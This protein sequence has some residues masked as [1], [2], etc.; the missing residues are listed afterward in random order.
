MAEQ[1]LEMRINASAKQAVN[2]LKQLNASLVQVRQ[3][4]DATLGNKEQ[5]KQ[6][7]KGI[8]ETSKTVQTESK[9][10]ATALAKISVIIYTLRRAFRF[11]GK[12]IKEAM[13]YREVTHLF[14]TVFS[15]VGYQ[16][17]DAFTESMFENLEDFQ[18]SF[19]YLGFDDKTVMNFQAVFAQMSNAMGVASE[20]AVN[21]SSSFTALG[22]DMT[23]LFNLAS[24]DEAMQKLQAGLAGQIRPLRRIGVDISKTTLM[25]EAYNR[26]INKS[27]EVMSAQEK[28]QLRY[29]AI[30]K[31]LQVAMGDLPKTIET[32]ANQ[33]RIFKEQVTQLARA[34]GTVFLPIVGVLLQYLNGIMMALT[35][36]LE[37]FAKLVGYEKPERE[38]VDRDQIIGMGDDFELGIGEEFEEAEESSKQI[39]RNLMG[40]DEINILDTSGG[41]EAY[42][43]FGFGDDIADMTENYLSFREKLIGDMD[44][45]PRNVSEKLEEGFENFGKTVQPTIDAFKNLYNATEPFTGGVVDTLKIFVNDVLFPMG[46][47]VLNEALPPFI[48]AISDAVRIFGTTV[49]PPAKDALNWY[50]ND[51]LKPIGEFVGNE[52]VEFLDELAEKTGLMSDETEKFREENSILYDS[53]YEIFKGVLLVITALTTFK[54]ITIIVTKVIALGASI[55]GIFAKGF[56][57]VVTVGKLVI[58]VVSALSGGLVLLAGAFGVTL[59][60]ILATVLAIGTLI[61]IVYQLYKNWDEILSWMKENVFS[62]YELISNVVYHIKKIFAGLVNF[63]GGVLTGDWERAFKGLKTIAINIAKGIGSAFLDAINTIIDSINWLAKMSNKIFGTEFG[64]IGN[65]DNPFSQIKE[66]VEWTRVEVDKMI[67][68]LKYKKDDKKLEFFGWETLPSGLEMPFGSTDEMFGGTRQTS[69]NI[70][71]NLATQIGLGTEASFPDRRS[72]SD[73]IEEQEVELVID[74]RQIGKAVIPYIRE[75][76][77]RLGVDLNLS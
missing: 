48:N 2:S 55:V 19:K 7:D 43:S 47:F 24:S 60:P 70:S 57:L 4:L 67:D 13:D 23:S 66:D 62:L 32:P 58:G 5:L 28:I 40:F 27:I 39:K 16:V 14:N 65:F 17:G 38:P 26:G 76:A 6:L 72:M 29:I 59:S 64:E 51:F 71:D 36:V 49:I 9:N 75:E 25:Q 61:F 20:D 54:A 45:I 74:G 42:S 52:L 30:M 18:E 77:G 63:I 31:Q 41:Q 37:G 69:Q 15:R 34:I 35:P 53:L 46:G 12:G 68:D 22:T 50:V 11:L 44:Y 73:Y 10:M 3:N 56:A 21:L 8:K 33:F 1:R